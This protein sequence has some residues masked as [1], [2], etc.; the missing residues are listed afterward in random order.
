MDLHVSRSECV[1]FDITLILAIPGIC[2]NL[3]DLHGYTITS[4]HHLV[5]FST[6]FWRKYQ[7]HGSYASK[8]WRQKLRYVQ[9]VIMMGIWKNSQVT[10]VVIVVMDLL[11]RRKHNLKLSNWQLCK[12][13]LLSNLTE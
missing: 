7:K 4:V 1:T 5:F 2:G 9:T 3:Q 6:C 13:S 11:T 12:I 10:H 8:N